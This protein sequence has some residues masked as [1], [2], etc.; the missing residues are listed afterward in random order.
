MSI[1]HRGEVTTI[2]VAE[3]PREMEKAVKEYE[4]EYGSAPA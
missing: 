1:G 3:E 2:A 4:S